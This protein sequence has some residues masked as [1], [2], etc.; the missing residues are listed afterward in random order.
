MYRDRSLL[1]RHSGLAAVL[2]AGAAASACCLASAAPTALAQVRPASA[3]A[4]TPRSVSTAP[5]KGTPQLAKTGATEQIR[6]LVQCGSTM[7]AVGSF[8][9]IERSKTTYTRNNVFSFSAA[10]PYRVTSWN[11]D[12][13]GVV[14]SIALSANCQD[15]YLGGAFSTVGGTGAN[16]IAEVSTS[17]GALVSGF[18]DDANNEVNT[19]LLTPAGHLLAGGEFTSIN[20]STDAFYASLD[21]ATGQDDGYLSLSIQ[22]SYSFPG[23]DPNSTEIY[24][25]QL[26]PNGTEVLAEGVF[27]SVGGLPRQQIFM[28]QLGASSGT[29]TGWTSAE[30]SRHCVNN[31][32]LYIKTATWSPDGSTIYIA[33]TG[34]HVHNW[35]K[36]TFPL[37]GLCDT[38]SAWR[39]TQTGGLKPTWVNYD[40]CYTLLSVAADTSAVYIGGH[41]LYG[42]NRDGCKSKGPGAVPDPGLGGINPANGRL[43]LNSAKTAGRYSRSRGLGAD[44][45]LLTTAGLWVASDNLDGSAMCDGVFGHAGICFLPYS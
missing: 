20:G 39:A 9:E 43:M 40:G 14:N 28:L 33:T 38:A 23:A 36:G 30:F 21:P 35:K 7:Y 42:D 45:M 3:T 16:N 25:Q 5:A 4:A 32:P 10:R 6:Q 34:L 41:E 37:N 24:N 15:A 26:S 27:T 8:T 1:R 31:H 13:N 17:T 22:G 44:D 12:V 2:I 11:P 18:A 19:L 29:V